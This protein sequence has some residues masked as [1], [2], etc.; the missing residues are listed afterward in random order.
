MNRTTYFAARTGSALAVLSMAMVAASA[1][2]QSAGQAADKPSGLTEIVVT[3]QKRPSSADKTP[4]S[5]SAVSGADIA[6]R[7]VTSFADIAASTPGV[8]IKSMGSGQ[9]EFEMRG[10]SSSGGN[11]PTVGFYLDDV[12]LTSPASAQNGKVVIDPSLYDLAQVE[13]LRGPQGTLYGSSSMGGTVKL[14]TNKPKLGVWEASGQATLS[15]TDGGGFNHAVNGMLNIPLGDTLA[16][17]VVGTQSDTSGFIKR[18]VLSDFPQASPD[19][20]VR[21]NVSAGTVSKV[22]NHSNAQD[23]V[24]TRVSLLWKPTEALTITP[25]FFYQRTHQAGSSTYDSDPGTLAH[26][27]PFDQPE[28]YTD[29]IKIG[30]LGINY[31]FT[32]FDVTSATSYWSRKSTMVQDNSENLPSCGGGFCADAP[33]YGPNG[34]GQIAAYET[35]PSKQFSQELRLTSNG[36]GRLKWLVGAYF[37]DF[38]SSW[39]L[40]T[41]VPNPAAFGFD[42]SMVFDLS[43]PTHIQQY[44]GFGELNYAVTDKLHVTVGLRAY[45]YSTTLDMVTGGVGSPTEDAT[46]TTQHVT[47]SSSGV[48]PKFDL[49]YQ[50]DPDTLVYATAARGFRPG[51]GNQPLPSLGTSAFDVGMKATLQGLG[52]ANG[53][54]PQSYGPDHLW[55]YEV[56]EKA[57]LLD[58]HLRINASAYFENWQDIQMELLP[59]GYPLFDNVNAAHIYGGEVEMQALLTHELSVGGS[60]GYTHATLA[61]SSHGFNAGDRLPDVP[62]WSGGA[63]ITYT[64]AIDGD[65]DLTIRLDDTY[66]GDRVGL[67]SY[68]GIVNYTQTPLA[69]Y[70]LLNLRIGVAAKKGWTIAFFANNLT[71]KHA[72]LENAA[73]LG[74]PNASYNRIVTN[75]PR[76]LGIDLSMHL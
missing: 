54:A 48:N 24:G 51:G 11:S 76:T 31:H 4:I 49:S 32:A 28:P 39:Q 15:G 34:T 59:S 71:N 58:R 53:V 1:Q 19:G 66:V 62:K 3:A 29:E 74:L 17:R 26:Y 7:G 20:T 10:M 6:A 52:Y 16:L 9:T 14:I 44:A 67:A 43:E 12:P 72:Q 56:G 13:V 61:D 68:Q 22:Y 73:Q 8:S 47:Q 46:F 5:I 27:Q 35:D 23:L 63:N 33:Y 60:I 41:Y 65:H 57:K 45:H 37:A 55:S 69:S 2:A 25:S 64:R 30:A 70:D 21:G 40:T 36:S 50:I 18:I 42:T 75:Q 38:R